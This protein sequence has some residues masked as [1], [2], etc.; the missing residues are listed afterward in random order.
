MF[1]RKDDGPLCGFDKKPCLKERCVQWVHLR[2]DHPQSGEALDLADCAL[3]WLPILL[4]ENAKEVR[5]TA[6]AVES[7]RN[8]VAGIAVAAAA[9]VIE[10]A[11]K[12]APALPPAARLIDER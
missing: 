8:V 11:S 12:S 5:Q 2:G 4:I 10:R 6:A 9:E 7:Q 3:K 1:G